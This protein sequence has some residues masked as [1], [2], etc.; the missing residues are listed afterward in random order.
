MLVLNELPVTPDFTIADAG[1]EAVSAA[2]IR[3]MTASERI[4][5]LQKSF[6]RLTRWLGGDKSGGLQIAQVLNS[7]DFARESRFLKPRSKSGVYFCG[8][9]ILRSSML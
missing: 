5:D 4:S 8:F 9:R 3:V 1:W 7:K 2:E 6:M